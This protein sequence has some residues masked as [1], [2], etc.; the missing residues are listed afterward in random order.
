MLLELGPWPAEDVRSWSKFARRILVELRSR[1]EELVSPD[2]VDL[3]SRII[4]QWSGGGTEGPTG[5]GSGD[6]P[7]RWSADLEPEVVEFLLN[8]LERCLRSETVM[9]WVRPDEAEAQRTFTTIVVQAFCD[10]LAAEGHGC[11]HYADEIMSS[12][13]NLMQ[14]S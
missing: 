12:L 11:R 8:G 4:D 1:E 6:A 2:V 9:S 13:S 5:G 10:G 7:F 3:W 14:H